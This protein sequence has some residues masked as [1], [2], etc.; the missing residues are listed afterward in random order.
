M[1]QLH[2]RFEPAPERDPPPPGTTEITF[3]KWISPK[4]PGQARDARASG[5]PCG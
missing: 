3:G 1:L 4:K 5:S 2:P